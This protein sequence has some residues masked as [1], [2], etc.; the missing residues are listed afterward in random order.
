MFE[1]GADGP[2]TLAGVIGGDILRRFTIIFHYGRQQ[3]IL[4]P[5][6]TPVQPTTM[7]DSASVLNK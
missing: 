1:E 6:G 5:N 4:I 2:K 3:I 7:A